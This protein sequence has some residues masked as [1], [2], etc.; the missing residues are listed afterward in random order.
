[1]A[2]PL[3]WLQGGPLQDPVS[4]SQA[5]KERLGPLLQ[6]SQGKGD[7]STGTNTLANNEMRRCDVC[8]D[9]SGQGEVWIR[10]AE[11]DKHEQA[12]THR[13]ALRAVGRDERIRKMKQ[14][15]QARKRRETKDASDE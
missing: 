12:R 5:A 8:S 2:Q 10:A 7:V 15:G 6:P 4:L 9:A 14:G 11:W 1:M 13:G 3:D